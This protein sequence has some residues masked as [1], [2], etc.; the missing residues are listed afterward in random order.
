MARALMAAALALLLPEPAT[1]QSCR[2]YPSG[3]LVARIKTRVEALRRIEREAAD[4]T[5]GL[6]TRPYDWLLGQARGAADAIADP[7]ALAA[8][9]ALARCRNY[10]RPVR[11]ECAGAAAMLVRMLEE[12]DAGAASRESKAAYAQ[13]MPQ[14]ERHMKLAPLSTPLRTTD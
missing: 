9:D 13:A 12:L 10:I 2:D 6:D 11:R 5:I 14:C 3:A 7:A 4:R 8:E 1:A